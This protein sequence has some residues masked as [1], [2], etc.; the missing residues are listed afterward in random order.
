VGAGAQIT[1]KSK[2]L[3]TNLTTVFCCSNVAS[4]VMVT[5]TIT[6][7]IIITIVF[8]ETAVFCF[9]TQ[10]C[11]IVGNDSF[12]ELPTSTFRVVEE[13]VGCRKMVATYS[14]LVIWK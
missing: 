6:T 1:A 5:V 8:S 9:I 11:P 10:C 4:D 7:T 12:E 2:Q 14:R 13:I 3:L